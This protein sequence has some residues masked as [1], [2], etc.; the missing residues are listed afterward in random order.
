MDLAHLVNRSL[1][2]NVKMKILINGF[3]VE[4]TVEEARELLQMDK[5]EKPLVAS[6]NPKKIKVKRYNKKKGW[7]PWSKEDE[8]IIIDNSF[9]PTSKLQRRF[10]PK[11]STAAVSQRRGLIERR[12]K[13]ETD[14]K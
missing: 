3:Y 8:Q 4:T 13:V 2:D 7:I 1:A 14:I 12:L 10:F 11:R 5:I 9:L 6:N